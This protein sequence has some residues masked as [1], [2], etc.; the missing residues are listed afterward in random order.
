MRKILAIIL[1]F[2]SLLIVFNSSSEVVFAEE[3]NEDS[4]EEQLSD[5]VQAKL[6]E[7]DFSELDEL[8][9]EDLV[10]T[11]D[12]NQNFQS[13][14]E[15][16]ISGNIALDGETLFGYVFTNIKNGFL[17]IFHGLAV[18]FVLAVLATIFE[19]MSL[20]DET[21]KIIRFVI[22]S[23]ILLILVTSAV[24]IISSSVESVERIQNQID[25]IFPILIPIVSLI[26]GGATVNVINP[27]ATLLSYVISNIFSKVLLP[28]VLFVITIT[29]ISGLNTTD[30][31]KKLKA[32]LVSLF[33]III[34]ISGTIFIFTL[35]TSGLISSV[36][37]TLTIRATRYS[38][39]NYIPYLGGY[40]SDGI[41]L[42][43]LS[44]ILIK[45]GIGVGAMLVLGGIV[46]APIVKIL[47]FIL[48]LKFCASLIEIAG[49]DQLSSI[50]LGFANTFKMLLAIILG[51]S[52]MLI[53]N[54]VFIIGVLNVI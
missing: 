44:F 37:D 53:L 42:A 11:L 45:N 38:I 34:A 8:I 20:N 23:L 41:S 4:L 13:L 16:I 2:V 43:K 47:V 1:C 6:N 46:I 32:F 40:I 50:V 30:R 28:I 5:E 31:F 39:K 49:G 48:S 7:I 35:T 10:F 25:A 24:S 19:A 22:S 27:S 33:K 52:M 54:L 14:V 9:T 15:G 29:V 36:T 18:V 51:I 12:G 26:G 3:T 21:K 17:N